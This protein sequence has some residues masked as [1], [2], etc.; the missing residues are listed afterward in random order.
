MTTRNNS[1]RNEEAFDAILNTLQGLHNDVLAKMNAV[2]HFMLEETVKNVNA[3]KMAAYT[4]AMS[5]LM[6]SEIAFNEKY[7]EATNMC[8]SRGAEKKLKIVLSEICKDK[9]LAAGRAMKPL[10]SEVLVNDETANE[11]KRGLGELKQSL[12][13]IKTCGISETLADANAISDADVGAVADA[14]SVPTVMSNEEL[15]QELK[16]LVGAIIPSPSDQEQFNE[17]VIGF[18]NLMD[19]VK[20]NSDMQQ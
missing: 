18:S 5:E 10:I 9:M 3:E 6:R 19:A 15:K 12:R 2:E 13:D 20:L 11:V 1:N 4:K 17:I 8:N 7:N 14:V 16:N